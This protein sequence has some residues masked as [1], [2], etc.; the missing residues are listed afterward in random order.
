MFVVLSESNA[1]FV[2]LHTMVLFPPS[3][4]AFWFSLG[5]CMIFFIPSIILSIKLSKYYRKM[6]RADEFK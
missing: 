2:C 3:Q 6:K 5:W 1:F 4:N